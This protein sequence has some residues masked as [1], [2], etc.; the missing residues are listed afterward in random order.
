[1]QF[2][3]IIA[4]KVGSSKIDEI[5]PIDEIDKMANEVFA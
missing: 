1:L 3:I 4:N 5:D 2:A